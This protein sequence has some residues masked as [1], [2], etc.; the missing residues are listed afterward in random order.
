MRFENDG[1]FEMLNKKEK[2]TEK[3]FASDTTIIFS[4]FSTKN[5][6]ENRSVALNI[7]A[8]GMCFESRCSFK[9]HANL[10]IRTDQN[11]ETVSGV[12]NWNLMRESTLAQVRWCRETTRK[13]G[14]W[15]SI[16]VKYF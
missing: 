1:R 3:R 7:S 14:R 15:Y 4:Y 6:T 2:R 10:Y 13:D 16:G 9:P 12:P 11:P 5:W 8:G